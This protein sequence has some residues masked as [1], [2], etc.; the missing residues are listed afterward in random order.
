[1]RSLTKMA[2]EFRKYG[3][4]LVPMGEG[5]LKVV[6]PLSDIDQCKMEDLSDEELTQVVSRFVTEE[7]VE[8]SRKLA[9]W[10]FG[11]PGTIPQ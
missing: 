2:D 11:P 10:T 7:R 6:L 4:E 8:M 5:R 1:M 3:L 9:Y